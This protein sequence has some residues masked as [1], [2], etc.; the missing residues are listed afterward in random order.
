M[1]KALG[2]ADHSSM[3]EYS[4]ESYTWLRCY[5]TSFAAEPDNMEVVTY[6][7]TPI[8]SPKYQE[9]VE[10]KGFVPT[11]LQLG[12]AQSWPNDIAVIKVGRWLITT[13]GVFTWWTQEDLDILFINMLNRVMMAE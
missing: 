1:V 5:F 7:E 9:A 10:R 6:T 12:G 3:S 4:R 2:Q 11:K 13:S 8:N